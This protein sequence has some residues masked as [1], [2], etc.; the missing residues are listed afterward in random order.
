RRQAI[1]LAAAGVPAAAIGA[2]AIRAI[3]GFAGHP[4]EAQVVA[5]ALPSVDGAGV[6]LHRALGHRGLPMVDPFLLL[7]EIHSER[8]EDYA[9]GFPTHPHR[10]F[11]TVTYVLEGAVD[12]R[13]S[14]GNHGHLG[15]GS[16]Q[17][18]TAGHGIVHA[19]MPT[20]ESSDTR[21][22]GFQL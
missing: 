6:H 17:W 19:E 8:I 10:G 12:H 9:P 13:D 2:G 7:D 4:R 18:M 20:H 15:P 16:V 22:W 11:E 21:L 1:A 5:D 3:R 14:L